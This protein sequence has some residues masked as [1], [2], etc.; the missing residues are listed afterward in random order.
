MKYVKLAAVNRVLEMPAVGLGTWRAQPEEM[1]KAVW[2][3]LEAGYRH[4]DTAFNYNTEETIGKVLSRWFSQGKGK[5]EDL[6]VTTKL[7][8][9]G[10]RAGDVARFLKMSLEKLQ[11]TY[12]DLYL[13]H[14]PFSFRCNEASFAPLTNEDGS[15]S[16]DVDSDIICTWQAMEEQVESGLA[17]TIG[18]SNFNGE[19]IERVY[20]SAKVKPAVLQVELHAYLQ[21]ADLR[22]LC[23]KLNIAVTAY[24]PL[25]SPGANKHFSSKYNYSI[26]DFPDILG[27]PVVTEL[28]KKYGKTPGQILLRHLVQQ[29]IIVI[30]K[31][32]NPDR[33]KSNIDLFDFELSEEDMCALNALDRGENGRIF[34]FLFFKGVERHPEYPFKQRIDG[35]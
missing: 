27:H 26:Q 22:A 5:R 12:V 31:S 28:S 34:D 9:C 4:I 2:A 24:A 21:Q 10:N 33:I 7:P 15:F 13:I 29:D 30:P 19:Q 3:A 35:W 23:K 32:S 16:L 8:N 1:E 18:L 20:N 17:R 6:F 14:M 25:G 11:L